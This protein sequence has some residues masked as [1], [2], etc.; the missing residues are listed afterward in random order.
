MDN[1][2]VGIMVYRPGEKQT[3]SNFYILDMAYGEFHLHSLN[4]SHKLQTTPGVLKADLDGT[5][6][7]ITVVCNFCSAHCLRQSKIVYNTSFLHFDC[8]YNCC[9]FLKHVS[10]SYNSFCV[11]Y[12][13]REDVV[14]LI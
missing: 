11:V 9:R 2:C 7:L 3:W 4:S 12:H 10:K 5:T 14:R 8:G 6:L 1:K 13:C